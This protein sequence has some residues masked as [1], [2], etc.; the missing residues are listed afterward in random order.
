MAAPQ[1]SANA[2]FLPLVLSSSLRLRPCPHPFVRIASLSLG[3]AKN[4]STSNMASFTFS[5]LTSL[6]VLAA[7][8]TTSLAVQPDLIRQFQ[9]AR[10]IAKRATEPVTDFEGTD[11]V[12]TSQNATT[13]L[14]SGVRVQPELVTASN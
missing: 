2:Y 5:R 12:C 1:G 6:L 13:S 10:A 14:L 11:S 8:M 4:G 9:E 3:G 7:S